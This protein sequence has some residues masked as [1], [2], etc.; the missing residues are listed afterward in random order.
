MKLNL[1]NIAS[2]VFLKVSPCRKGRDEL[3]ARIYVNSENQRMGKHA[4]KRVLQISNSLWKGFPKSI[5]KAVIGQLE[6]MT[7]S[8]GV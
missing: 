1:L 3:F 8:Y 6:F 7:F 5:G 2:A 4:E